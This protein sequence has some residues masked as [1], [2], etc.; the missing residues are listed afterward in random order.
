MD[1]SAERLVNFL[2][3]NGCSGLLDCFIIVRSVHSVFGLG[4]GL[5]YVHFQSSQ[6]IL[7]CWCSVNCTCYCQ[8]R[9]SLQNDIGRNCISP[10]DLRLKDV[11]LRRPTASFS[12]KPTGPRNRDKSE[13]CMFDSVCVWEGGE[14]G[15]G[16]EGW[17][18]VNT[19][20]FP[21][22]PAMYNLYDVVEAH[23]TEYIEPE[24]Y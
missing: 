4:L 12:H 3:N 11:L 20:C 14:G 24:R 8:C 9:I 22:A 10:G 16:G 7:K 1:S 5:G 17:A 6:L 19:C 23:A 2:N 15:R 18:R 21:L 13:Q